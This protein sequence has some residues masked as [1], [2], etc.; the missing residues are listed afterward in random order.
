MKAI[1]RRSTDAERAELEALV[2]A[3]PEL[4]AEF[5]RLEAEARLAK[6]ILP[7]AAATE[8]V[9]G[10][11]P[12]YARERLQ[13][14]VRQALGGA[15]Q[16]TVNTSR[17]K[18]RWLLGFAGAAGITLLFIL[19][20]SPTS[21]TP[22]VE[23]A[24]LDS[25]GVTRGAADTNEVVLLKQQA[26]QG[27]VRLFEKLQDLK[28]WEQTWPNAGRPCVKVIY[29]RTAGEVRVV[30]RSRSGA[31]E[32]IISVEKDLATALREAETFIRQQSP[33]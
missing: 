25:A 33:R 23:V 27:A 9:G 21:T 13:T 28:A 26:S 4:R 6:E 5:E 16:A 22:I 19:I 24:M 12:A 11:F 3:Q 14:K 32:K 29:D 8:S 30:G 1:G 17:V 20:Q 10:E 7:L 2:S 18:W 31:Y 15:Q